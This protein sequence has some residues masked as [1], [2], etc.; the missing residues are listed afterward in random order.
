MSNDS[1]MEEVVAKVPTETAEKGGE[2]KKEEEKKKPGRK[3]K[4]KSEDKPR[5]KLV[6]VSLSNLR[7][8]EL[9]MGRTPSIEVATVGSGN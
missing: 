2:P 3:P 9:E 7:E 1:N 8:L 5:K 4:A 6:S